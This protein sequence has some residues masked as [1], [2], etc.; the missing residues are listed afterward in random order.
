MCANRLSGFWEWKGPPEKPPP[1]RQAQHDRNRRP[2]PVVLLRGHRDEVIPGA[3]DEVGELHLGDGT[4][5]HQGGAGRAGDDRRLRERHVDHPPRSELLLEPV[6]DLERAA[7]DAHVLAEHEHALVVAHLLPEPVAD[8]LEVGLLGHYLWCGVSSS[9]AVAKTP[10]RS[11]AGSGSGD[12]SARCSESFRSFLTPA[13]ISSSSSSVI[14]AL[15][16]SQMR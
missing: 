1:G 5:A 12:S 14:A 2:G 4:H 15:S 3:G 10:S 6:R 7:V 8:R 16:R 9:S 13:V 11:V